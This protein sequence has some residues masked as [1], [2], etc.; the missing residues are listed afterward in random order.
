MGSEMCIR[1]RT[2]IELR[3]INR[4]AQIPD[5]EAGKI[6]EAFVESTATQSAAG[7][8]GLGLAICKQIVGAHKGRIW[9]DTSHPDTCFV[10]E[11]PRTVATE[12]T[13][14]VVDADASSEATANPN[15]SDSDSDYFAG[16]G[17]G[18]AA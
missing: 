2:I 16:G 14:A 8:T 4:G 9:L 17:G 6:F 12:V 1:D 3:V 11:L 13:E 15:P 5:A 18:I 7:G 10:V